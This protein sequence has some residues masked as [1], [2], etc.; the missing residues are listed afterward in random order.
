MP[1]IALA[2]CVQ[3]KLFALASTLD[4]FSAS[5]LVSAVVET[6]TALDAAAPARMALTLISSVSKEA[7]VTLGEA[8]TSLAMASIIAM[9]VTVVS[10]L[11]SWARISA[12]TS[13]RVASMA[14]FFW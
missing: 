3:I 8:I 1:L 9:L 6:P 2:S 5:V 4:R 7:R 11:E 14:A 12:P 13:D 10:L